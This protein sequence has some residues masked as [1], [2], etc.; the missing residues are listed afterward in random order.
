MEH[1]PQNYVFAPIRRN[2]Q[3]K[4]Q[5]AVERAGDIENETEARM[6]LMHINDELVSHELIGGHVQLHSDDLVWLK[7]M[8]DG[9]K[10]PVSEKDI[11]S[12]GFAEGILIGIDEVP[13]DSLRTYI[14]QLHVES[15]DPLIAAYSVTA[16]VEDAR[17]MVKTE[18]PTEDLSNKVLAKQI[19][20]LS[21]IEDPSFKEELTS[22]VN[23]SVQYQD[24]S[25]NMVREIGVLTAWLMAHD[26]VKHNDERLT[27]LRYIAK[28]LLEESGTFHIVG[29]ELIPREN[30]DT[31][32][33]FVG[34]FEARGRLHAVAT[35]RDYN[36]EESGSYI[37][38]QTLQ[39]AFV[40][41]D[42]SKTQRYVP[43]KY[44]T[45]FKKIIQP[46]ANTLGPA[47]NPYDHHESR[48]RFLALNPDI[49]RVIEVTKQDN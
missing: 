34:P 38:E 31:V 37:F 25:F 15:D 2:I 35:L 24:L 47:V 18:V 22:L 23:L 16:V 36:V 33:F 26:E 7:C 6:R 45:E 14:Y 49:F 29:E 43:L 8:P 5:V 19:I 13:F 40:L 9:S 41:L 20:I 12:E 4:I 28:M 39:I 27:A 17:L 46:D 48:L 3:E 10:E 32:E 11:P 44:L 42:E 30:E 21:E 1:I